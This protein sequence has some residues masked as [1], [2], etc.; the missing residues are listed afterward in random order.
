MIHISPLQLTRRVRFRF[1]KRCVLDGIPPPSFRDTFLSLID[2]S[3]LGTI[4]NL[5]IPDLLCRDLQ[6][7]R[8]KATEAYVRVL[9]GGRQGALEGAADGRG[10]SQ[11]SLVA[12]I[13]GEG[14][15]FSLG[16]KVRFLS[17]KCNRDVLKMSGNRHSCI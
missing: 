1:L 11:I 6:K 4:D 14:P 8:L 17:L 5:I 2:G 9:N 12:S 7:L 13:E 15:T 3:T 10:N 16:I